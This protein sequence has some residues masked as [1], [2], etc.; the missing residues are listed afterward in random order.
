MSPHP[1]SK[2]GRYGMTL[3]LFIWAFAASSDLRGGEPAREVTDVFRSGTVDVRVVRF[4]PAGRGR[5]PA[6]VLL[7]GADGWG[8][9]CG[10]RYA[11]SGLTDAGCVAVL[12]RYYDRTATSD[13]VPPRD[14]A[15]FTRWLKGEAQGPAAARSRKHFADWSEAVRDAV[16][17]ARKLPGV[18]PDRVAVVGFSL[19]GYLAL[20]AAPTCDPPVR[21]VVDLFGGL[22]E[23]SRKGLGRLPPT[24]IL[25]GEEDTVV[26]VTEAYKAA[27]VVLAQKQ[28]VEID[29]RPGVGHVYVQLGTAVPE[30]KE[31][32]RGRTRMVEFLTR[33]LESGTAAAHK[34]DGK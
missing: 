28:H 20:S 26:P 11:A 23:E 10:Y 18:D 24:L 22:P 4:E 30:P 25:H 13:A 3:A 32:A 29:V 14:Q 21:A 7:H 16:A 9:M 31:V 17:Y 34:P 1:A 19:G 5:R 27:G 15:D 12:V 33:R 2:V 8:Q 6:V